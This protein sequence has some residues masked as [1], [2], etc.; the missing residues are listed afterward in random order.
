MD[1]KLG[2]KSGAV[3]G[4]IYGV[5]VGII[6]VI[7]MVVAKEEV[8]QTMQAALSGVEIPISMDQLYTI[9]MISTVP[10]SAV[11][12]VISG[13]VFG[14]VFLLLKD[15]MIGKGLKKKG[16][17]FA[18]LLFICLG[19]AELYKAGNL[20][21]AI[22]MLRFSYLPLVP[23]SFAAFLAFGYFLGMFWE[24]FEKRK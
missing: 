17:F 24:R 5:F 7:Y 18:V 22:F 6:N 1:W 4:A 16:L 21:G 10:S 3:A 23:L 19:V 20:A 14:T 2:F 13:L 11:M 12:G 15:E 9:S 8:I